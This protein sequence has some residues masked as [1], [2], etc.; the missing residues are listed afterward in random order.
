MNIPSCI[1]PCKAKSLQHLPVGALAVLAFCT[2]LI[3]AHW[4]IGLSP[5][6]MVYIGV[7]RS[8]LDGNGVTY[9][10]DMGELS[11]VNHYPPLYPFMI[12]GLARTGMDP[13]VAAKWMNASLFAANILLVSSIVFAVTRSGG[14]SWAAAFFFFASLPIAQVHSMAWSEALFLFLGFSGLLCL[15]RYLEEAKRWA[16]YASSSAIA[17][18]CLARYAGVAF[19]WVAL[20][21]IFLRTRHCGKK[22]LADGFIFAALSCLPLA[23]WVCRS[24]WLAGS[25][26]NRTFGFHPPTGEDLVTALNSVC[27]WIFPG[28]ILQVPISMRLA[29][30]GIAVFL[31]WRP[32]RHAA[33]P[34]PQVHRLAGAFLFA[35]GIFLFM[36]RSLFDSAIPFDTRILAPAYVA[37]MILVI[38]AVAQPGQ[39]K[40]YSGAWQARLA[41][42]AFIIALAAIQTTKAAGWWKH[43]YDNGIGYTGL[44]WRN[45]EA[46]KF[47]NTVAGA[48]PVFTNVPDVIYMLTG[49]RTIMIPRKIDPK[50]RLTNNR[51]ES[52]IALMKERLGQ[53][54]GLVAYFHAPQRLW[55]LPSAEE[56]QRAGG[57]RLIAVKRDGYIYQLDDHG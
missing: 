28:G 39:A 42:W 55:Y 35:Y 9:L 12:A 51:Y 8:L 10:N 5:D 36:A 30:L 41:P 16:L 4:G 6:S 37:A 54:R 32:T 18:S 2:T 22:R 49:R 46:L 14:A 13:L 56:L 33:L 31:V 34:K 3:A 50:S 19:V 21:G 25:A 29:A 45:S 24:L 57:L 47:I 11:P 52:E 7:A 15:A 20:L 26:A 53:S 17:L 40:P 1:R 27:L 48:T 23:L 43:A 44:V 38:S